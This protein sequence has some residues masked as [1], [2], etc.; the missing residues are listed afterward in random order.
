M[1]D[2][3][4]L[5][6]RSRH[7]AGVQTLCKAV[8][9]VSQG[10]ARTSSAARAPDR[11]V[12]RRTQLRLETDGHGPSHKEWK[13]H[14]REQSV[15]QGGRSRTRVNSS[16]LP[17]KGP[18]ARGAAGAP[19]G[20][21]Q[22]GAKLVRVDGRCAYVVYPDGIGRSKLTSAL[23]EKKLGDARHRAQLEHRAEARC[24]LADSVP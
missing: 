12:R 24:L 4:A 7:A 2:L 6:D 1:S 15:S 8:N 5:L 11:S 21:D 9:A 18:P 3:R 17:L 10:D 20:R 22:S 13:G 16:V 23:I 19:A 14:H